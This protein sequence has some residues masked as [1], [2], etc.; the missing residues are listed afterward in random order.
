MVPGS[1]GDHSEQYTNPGLSRSFI[2]KESRLGCSVQNR[3]EH[4]ATLSRM[5]KGSDCKVVD[6]LDSSK[7]GT[8]D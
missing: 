1:R 4:A 3:Q 8:L 5:A 2:S 7:T 6:F